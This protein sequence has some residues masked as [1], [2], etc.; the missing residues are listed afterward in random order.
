MHSLRGTFD[1][2]AST[3]MPDAPR[4]LMTGH[5]GSGTDYRHYLQQMDSH[6]PEYSELINKIDFGL[7]LERLEG[8]LAGLGREP[9]R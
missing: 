5:K 9:S 3:V 8:A 2:T 1:S 6:V 4:R 7:D